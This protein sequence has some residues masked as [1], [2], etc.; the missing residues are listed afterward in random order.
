VST[1][2]Q[3]SCFLLCRGQAGVRM[4]AALK[5]HAAQRSTCLHCGKLA[6][7]A[8]SAVQAQV[9]VQGLAA[10]EPTCGTSSCCLSAASSRSSPSEALSRRVSVLRASRHA[11]LPSAMN[12]L[13][14][15]CG[16]QGTGHRACCSLAV[17]HQCGSASRSLHMWSTCHRP[18][19]ARA[20]KRCKKTRYE[21]CCVCALCA[22]VHV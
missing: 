10:H 1:H 2:S 5:Q 7:R 11:S 16:A 12:P 13:R 21:L 9:Q 15:S 3:A 4:A 6:G 22:V 8:C 14:L 20:P 18:Q 17:L 19:I